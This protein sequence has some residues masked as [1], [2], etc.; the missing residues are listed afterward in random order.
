MVE[1]DVLRELTGYQPGKTIT[2]VR[3]PN[4]DPSTDYRPAYLDRIEIQ[5]GFTDM[6]A[7]EEDPHRRLSGERRLRSGRRPQAGGHEYPDQLA[8]TAGKRRPLHRPEHVKPPFDDINVR[9]AVIAGSTAKRCVRPAAVRWP[10]TSRRTSSRPGFPGS[11]SWRSR[12]PKGS[13]F[14]FVEPEGD[15]EVAAKYFRKAGF[16]SGKYEGTTATIT[17]VG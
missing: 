10:A 4:W 6:S 12:K 7:G 8:L 1:N 11:M 15:P 13:E 17:M 9:K 5:E 14:D 16:K 2:M 3:N